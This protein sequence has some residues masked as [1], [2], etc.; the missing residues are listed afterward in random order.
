MLCVPLRN[1]LLWEAFVMKISLEQL[2]PGMAAVVT[3][4]GCSRM[5]KNRL[6]DFGLVPGTRV[7]CRHR[8]PDGAL[9]ALELRGTVLAV[10]TR[11]LRTITGEAI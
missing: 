9:S 7:C 6:A 10:R 5:L 1:A 11:D 4:L 2:Q 3:G 8:S